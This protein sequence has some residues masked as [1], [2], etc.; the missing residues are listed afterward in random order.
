MIKN[1]SRVADH[2][3]VVRHILRYNCSSTNNSILTDCHA[4]QDNCTGTD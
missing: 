2:C 4:W 1:T 3:C